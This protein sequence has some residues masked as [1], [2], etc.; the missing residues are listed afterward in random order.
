M[1]QRVE[2]KVCSKCGKTKFINEFCFRNDR[3][4]YKA[5][6]K[7]C[8]SLDK[9]RWYENNKT[10]VIEY[11]VKQ[12]R[13]YYIKNTEKVKK[14]NSE[15]RGQNKEKISILKHNW[16]E[17]NKDYVIEKSTKYIRQW[18]KD[19]SEKRK[20]QESRHRGFGFN[21]VNN[22]I[23]S[24]QSCFD[25]HHVWLEDRSDF[26]IYIPQFLHKLHFHSHKDIRSMKRINAIALDFWIN[27]DFY[28]ELYGL[29]N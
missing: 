19:N 24:A 29:V 10:H 12:H 9:K 14:Q 11:N 21:P 16:Y 26:V 1:C 15:Y 2:L 7:K 18:R 3:Q 20:A 28:N 5:Q 13:E 8:D 6:C 22:P 27:E 25:A 17:E 4:K 23:K